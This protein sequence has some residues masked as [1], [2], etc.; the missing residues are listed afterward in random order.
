MAQNPI[1]TFE[2]ER[3]SAFGPETGIIKA[4]GTTAAAFVLTC[5]KVEL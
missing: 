2:I 3:E 4:D 5:N 1:V